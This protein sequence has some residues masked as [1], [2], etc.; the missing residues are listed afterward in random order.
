MHHPNA[1]LEK[2]ASSSLRRNK[3]L[4]VLGALALLLLGISFLGVQRM[5]DEQRDT[6][7]FHFARLMENIHEQEVFLGAISRES[8][9]GQLNP[10]GILPPYLQQPLPEEG[11]NIYLGRGLRFSLPYSVK[12]NPDKIAASQH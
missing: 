10:K 11:P 1:F 5:V 7:Q 12:I 3:G 8:S 4:L 9:K 2:L 6:L